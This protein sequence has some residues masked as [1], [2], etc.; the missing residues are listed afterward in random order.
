MILSEADARDLTK[1]VL[2]LSKAD[3][4]IVT[5]D[6]SEDKHIRFAQNMATTNGAPSEAAASRTAIGC[7]WQAARARRRC[8]PV[9]PTGSHPA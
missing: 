3:S 1:K 4:C 2:A 6:G 5:I 8:V 7:G 9:S